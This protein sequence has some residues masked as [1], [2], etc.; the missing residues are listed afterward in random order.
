VVVTG[1]SSGIGEAAAGR[2]ARAGASVVACARRAGRLEAL[3]ARIT[4]AGGRVVTVPADV[5]L[6]ADRERVV[7]RAL[8]AF[9]GIHALVNNAG[10]AQ[11]GPAELVPLDAVRRNF[12]TNVFAPLALAQ[13]VLPRFRAQGGGRIVNVSSLAGRLVWP[14]S[15]VYAATKHALEALSDGLRRETA[16]F[17]VR[18]V[19]IEPG[20]VETEFA[21]AAEAASGPALDAAG[22]YGRAAEAGGRRSARLRRMSASGEDVAELVLR[23]LT[24]RRPRAR[25]AT[26][27]HARAAL[28]A[29]R[30]L[31]GP[32]LDSLIGATSRI[33]RSLAARETGPPAAR[34]RNPEAAKEST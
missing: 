13:L 4:A 23:A 1:A 34:N 11:R 7:E 22:P 31:P 21:Q 18:V 14:W 16:P 5:T 29:A 26:P 20:F 2:L 24:S 3:A 8:D 12:E 33:N 32:L 28:V 30:I 27:F 15:A 17:G 10:Y 19:L 9:G 25:Y 6:A